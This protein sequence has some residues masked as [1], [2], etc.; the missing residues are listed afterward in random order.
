MT[1]IVWHLLSWPI[2]VMLAINLSRT[3]V[4]GRMAKV[5]RLGLLLLLLGIVVARRGA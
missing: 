4:D 1:G 5:V 2:A 3:V